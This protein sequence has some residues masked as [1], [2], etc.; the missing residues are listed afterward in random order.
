[1]LP[2]VRSRLGNYR[3]A[4]YWAPMR[5]KGSIFLFATRQLCYCWVFLTVFVSVV[6]LVAA[7]LVGSEVV[8]VVVRVRS[9]VAVEGVDAGA[10]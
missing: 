8:V 5:V 6:E 9:S 10:F 1:M 3:R 4:C 2:H 7:G